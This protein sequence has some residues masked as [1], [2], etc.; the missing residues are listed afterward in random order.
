[1]QLLQLGIELFHAA[2][3][4]VRHTLSSITHYCHKVRAGVQYYSLQNW[5]SQPEVSGA[6]RRDKQTSK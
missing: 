3:I 1:S 5:A 6:L 4:T 2:H